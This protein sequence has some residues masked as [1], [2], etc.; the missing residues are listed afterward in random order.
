MISRWPISVLIGFFFIG[1]GVGSLLLYR[2]IISTDLDVQLQKLSANQS[3][4]AADSF[5]PEEWAFWCISGDPGVIS[6]AS[7]FVAAADYARKHGLAFAGPT[8]TDSDTSGWPLIFVRA[9]GTFVVLVARRYLFDWRYGSEDCWRR[10]Q[11]KIRVTNGNLLVV[12]GAR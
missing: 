8:R 12:E 9:D 7:H 1:L 2:S 11:S 10:G 5:G 4:L 6:T 3:E